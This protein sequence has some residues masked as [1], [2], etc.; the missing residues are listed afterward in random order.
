M[1]S[2]QQR[3]QRHAAQVCMLYSLR[4]AFSPCYGVKSRVLVVVLNAM[5]KPSH[6]YPIQGIRLKQC[7][8]RFWYCI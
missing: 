2:G 3:G 5:S 4:I 6:G 8:A 1:E 7:L